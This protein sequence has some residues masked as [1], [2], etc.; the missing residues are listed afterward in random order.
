MTE[1]DVERFWS[2]VEVKAPEECWPWIGT[3]H[4][5]G[6]GQIHLIGMSQRATHVSLAL[7]GRPR[8]E[9]MHALHSCHNRACVNP[10]HLRWGSHQENM[11]DMIDRKER[12]LTAILPANAPKYCKRGHPL[13]AEN[14]RPANRQSRCILCDRILSRVRARRYRE[15]KAVCRGA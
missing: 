10:R 3:L 7:D 4:P 8:P 9:K 5:D 13:T 2:K 1:A 14:R 12:E 11:N 15:R 6:Y